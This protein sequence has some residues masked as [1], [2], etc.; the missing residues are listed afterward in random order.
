MAQDGILQ[1]GRME[2]HSHVELS[3]IWRDGV[4]LEYWLRTEQG[5]MIQVSTQDALTL[6]NLAKHGASWRSTGLT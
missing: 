1:L 5:A 6:C 2:L 3:A 4:G